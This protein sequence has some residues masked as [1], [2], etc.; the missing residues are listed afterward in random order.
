[1]LKIG[2]TGGIGSGKSVVGEIFKVLQVPV[3]DADAEAKK[4]MVEDSNVRRQLIGEFGADT[5]VEEKLNRQWLASQVFNNVFKLDKLN[6]I[7]HPATIQAADDWMNKQTSH[8]VIKEAAL[9][10]ESG[11]AAHLDYI[12]GVTAPVALRIQRVMQRDNATRDEVKARMSK[13][14]KDEIKMKLC[15]FVL[16]NDE[17][18]LLTPQVLAL[19]ERLLSVQP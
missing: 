6:A 17:Q 14:I 11:S 12:I 7:V 18:Q 8:Y 16:V 13:Q 19:H 5:F 15:D 2:L 10:F 1:M 9:L 4:V 3:F